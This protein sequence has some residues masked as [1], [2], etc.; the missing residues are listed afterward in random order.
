[1]SGILLTVIPPTTY[2]FSPL[3]SS[4]FAVKMPIAS[5]IDVLGY[6]SGSLVV[7]AH[8]MNLPDSGGGDTLN[9]RVLADGWNCDDPGVDFG[10]SGALLASTLFTSPLTTPS[11]NV[12]ALSP[13]PALIRLELIGARSTASAAT[14][15]VRLSIELSLK[16]GNDAPIMLPRSPGAY[17]GYLPTQDSVAENPEATAPLRAPQARNNAPTFATPAPGKLGVVTR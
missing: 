9:V 4:T 11:F 15:T 7:R 12:S 13:L 10:Q 3:V 17:V 14:M 2:S 5:R 6:E 16:T 1:M 8:A